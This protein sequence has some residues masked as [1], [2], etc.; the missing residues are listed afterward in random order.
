MPTGKY[1]PPSVTEYGAVETITMTA[2]DKCD[3]GTDDFE[4]QSGLTGSIQD[5]EAS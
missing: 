2:D 3:P 5:C 4:D 1:T